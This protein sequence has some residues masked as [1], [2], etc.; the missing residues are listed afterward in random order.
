MGTSEYFKNKA[1]NSKLAAEHVSY[2]DYKYK[3]AIKYSGSNSIV[4]RKSNVECIDYVDN[5]GF[6]TNFIVINMNTVNAIEFVYTNFI[7]NKDINKVAALNFASYKNP[8]GKFLEG[9]SAQEEFLCH[10]S[11]LYNVLN[12]YFKYEYQYNCGNLNKGMYT[13]FAIY[14]PRILFD[15]K[16]FCD[17]I[18]CPT[19]N[20][21]PLIKYGSFTSE[22]NSKA[23]YYRTCL[24]RS[25][26]ENEKVDVFIA[27]AWGCG[28][29]KQNPYEVVNDFIKVFESSDVKHVILAIPDK[30]KYQIFAN[31]INSWKEIVNANQ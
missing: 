5:N 16:Y 4:F 24:L 21:N 10:H 19:P 20:K 2:M 17:I 14:S 9:S 8:G 23:L 12:D 15:E 27:G 18:T 26:C 30:E 31:Q 28:V 1:E 25:I 29:F 22:E 3:E 11:T 6:S 7:H 13:N